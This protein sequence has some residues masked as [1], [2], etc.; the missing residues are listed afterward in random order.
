MAKKIKCKTCDDT[1]EIRIESYVYNGEPHTAD[2][3]TQPCP[4]CKLKNVYDEDNI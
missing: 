3:E 1:G 4:D 2:T